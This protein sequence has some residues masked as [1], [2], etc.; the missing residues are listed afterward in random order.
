MEEEREFLLTCLKDHRSAGFDNSECGQTL[1]PIYLANLLESPR[2]ALSFF[3]F[4]WDSYM[5]LHVSWEQLKLL[6]KK[7]FQILF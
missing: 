6:Y 2:K 3:G 1:L 4:F 7:V 5:Y